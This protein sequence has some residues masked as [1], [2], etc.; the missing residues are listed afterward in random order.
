MANTTAN[1]TTKIYTKNGDMGQTNL[2]ST[3]GF[4][5]AD[6]IF[7]ALG[8]LDELSAHIGHLCAL[9]REPTPEREPT[10]V[11][12]P[13]PERD[14]TPDLESDLRTIQLTLLNIGAEFSMLGKKQLVTDL[15]VANLEQRTDYYNDMSPK[16]TEFIL[17][18]SSA[19][20]AVANICRTVCRRAERNMWRTMREE[21]KVY[22]MGYLLGT[23][24]ENP[25]YINQLSSFRYINRL[26]SF[27]FALSRYLA[28]GREITRSMY[29][30]K[31]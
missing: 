23:W 18:G 20:D 16:L 28:A 27:L 14:A 6:V 8:D 13:V 29:E 30:K 26:S 7:D 15:D 24:S 9:T 19:P 2:Y 11:R 5:K 25:S 12:E 1:A 10:P 21:G 31:I 4:S 22:K 3:K 17:Q